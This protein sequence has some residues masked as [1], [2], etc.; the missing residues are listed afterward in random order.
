MASK[1]TLQAKSTG[2]SLKQTAASLGHPDTAPAQETAHT[3]TTGN[4]KDYV[5]FNFICNSDLVRKIKAVSVK[6]GISIRRIMEKAIRD[7][8][9]KYEAKNGPIGEVKE[10]SIEDLGC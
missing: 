4:E 6:E 3:P 5:R 9:T 8:L 10:R 7:W 2:F 1:N